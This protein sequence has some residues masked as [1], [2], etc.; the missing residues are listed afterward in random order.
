MAETSLRKAS[1][2]MTKGDEDKSESEGQPPSSHLR[3]RDVTPLRVYSYS[4]VFKV[5]GD[6]A[7]RQ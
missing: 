6:K 5:G 3:V 4:R 2:S 7:G 1:L